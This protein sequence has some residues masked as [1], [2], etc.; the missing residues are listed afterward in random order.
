MR[1][2]GAYTALVTPMLQNG[3]VDYDGFAKNIEFQITQGIAGVVPVGTTG[4][5]PTLNWKEHN[6]AVEHTL[7]VVAGRCAIIAGTGSNST[8]EC[9][10]STRHAV[11]SGAKAVLMVDCYYNGPSSQELRDDYYAVVAEE[12]PETAL[13]PYVI[14]GRSSTALAAEDL[15]ILSAK[16]PNINTVKEATGDLARMARTRE[17]CGSDFDILSGDDD[18][19]FKMLTDSS[20]KANGVISVVTNIAPKAVQDMVTAARSGDTAK[21][22]SLHNALSPLFGVVTVKVDNER[23]LPNGQTAVVSDKYRNPVA[24]KTIMAGLGLPAGNIRKPLGKMTKPG[25]EAVRNAV[26][27]VWNNNPEVLQ[28]LVDFYGID[29]EAR[30]NDDNCWAPLVY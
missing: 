13:I 12:F 24:I 19:T 14:P 8:D 21:A 16:Y 28:P 22:E 6:G 18:L 3:A 17:L 2:E 20:I 9:L 25:V 27:T 30:I 4:E 15:A 7:E 10:A 23:K 5:S 26:K 1:F 11:Q 29:I